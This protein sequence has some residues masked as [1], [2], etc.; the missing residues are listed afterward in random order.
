MLVQD[1]L[2]PSAKWED[3]YT[4]ALVETDSTRAFALITQAQNAIVVRARRLFASGDESF[5]EKQA[6]DSALLT[7][8]LLGNCIRKAPQRA[9]QVP[10]PYK[11][12]ASA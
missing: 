12:A 7:L 1:D 5:P 2:P 9:D 8:K 3:L 11:A 10:Q 6:L 4:A